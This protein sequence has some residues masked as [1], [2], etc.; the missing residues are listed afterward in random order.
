MSRDGKMLYG[1]FELIYA[2]RR[3]H[4]LTQRQLCIA[5]GFDCFASHGVM[6]LD[7]DSQ[8]GSNDNH[9]LI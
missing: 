3:R 6:A 1:P 7:P 2:R 4:P 8:E 5:T 9:V